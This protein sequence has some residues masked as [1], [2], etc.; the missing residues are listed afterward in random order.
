MLLHTVISI[1]LKVILEKC[2]SSILDLA[3]NGCGRVDAQRQDCFIMVGVS[4]GSF[5]L[6]LLRVIFL[7]HVAGMIDASGSIHDIFVFMKHTDAADVVL[8]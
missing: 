5:V 1:T 3:S 7:I 2:L 8:K 4:S 6:I